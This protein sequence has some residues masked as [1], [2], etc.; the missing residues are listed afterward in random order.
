MHST[1]FLLASLGALTQLASAKPVA[2]PGTILKRSNATSYYEKRQQ[3]PGLANPH[4]NIYGP[5]FVAM[6]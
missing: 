6:G 4:S 1:V 3:P 5:D 2:F